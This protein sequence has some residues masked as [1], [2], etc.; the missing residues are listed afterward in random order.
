L[1]D[2]LPNLHR[3]YN[4]LLWTIVTPPCYRTLELIL[5]CFGYINSFSP[6]NS[7]IR[8]VLLLSPVCDE[9]NRPHAS[10]QVRGRDRIPTQHPHLH[11][12]SIYFSQNFPLKFPPE[13][14][15][16]QPCQ[17]RYL[18]TCLSAPSLTLGS[19]RTGGLLCHHL[20]TV[21]G[22]GFS[23]HSLPKRIHK[24]F[25]AS[26][27][28]HVRQRKISKWFYFSQGKRIFCNMCKR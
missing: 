28:C 3:L 4:R 5:L 18:A 8:K 13:P 1:S 16:S 10:Q 24:W 14:L 6:H 27:L 26:K 23:K 12:L 17:Q 15:T 11:S 22:T 25:K 7:P 19:L 21:P 9:P 20:T 2:F